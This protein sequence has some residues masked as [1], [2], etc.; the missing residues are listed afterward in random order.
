[1]K[2][3]SFHVIYFHFTMAH[4]QVVLVKCIY[5]FLKVK[6]HIQAESLQLH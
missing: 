6:V 5:D 4:F 1:M 3:G 2:T